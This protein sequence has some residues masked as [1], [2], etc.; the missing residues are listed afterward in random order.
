MARHAKYRLIS[1]RH[2]ITNKVVCNSSSMVSAASCWLAT[3]DGRNYAEE[4]TREEK[5]EE[6]EEELEKE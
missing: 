4:N 2:K 5:K 6:E 1:S 3:T